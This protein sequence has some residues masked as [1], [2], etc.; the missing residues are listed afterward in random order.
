MKLDKSDLYIILLQSVPILLIC[1]YG[2]FRC[3]NKDFKDPLE[4]SLFW[5]FDGWSITHVVWFMF[6]GIKFP[7]KLILVTI[8]GIIWELF[9]N[10]YGKERPGWLGG[11]GDCDGLVSKNKE[12]GNW[13][14]GKWSDIAC[15]VSGFL[16]GKYISKII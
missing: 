3:H 8:L 12:D 15:N 2:K 5:G 16:I 4:T 13:W 1:M 10:Y 6:L 11:Y 7:N 9:E 14:Y